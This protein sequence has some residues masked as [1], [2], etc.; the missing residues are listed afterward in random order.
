MAPTLSRLRAVVSLLK[1]PPWPTL[2]T[3]SLFGWLAMAFTSRG[4]DALDLCISA[5]GALLDRGWRAFQVQI[6]MMSVTGVALSLMIML[7]AMMSLILRDPIMHIWNRSLKRRRVRSLGMFF[8]SYCSLWAVCAPML[9]V[10]GMLLRVAASLVDLP[11]LLLALGLV[12]LWQITPWKQ[13]LLNQCHWTPRLSA[14]GWAADRDCLCYG[15]REGGLCVGTCW[16]LMVLPFAVH[17]YHLLFM[18]AAS[19]I[20]VSERLRPGRPA[21]WTIAGPAGLVYQGALKR[22]RRTTN[23][24]PGCF[25]GCD[26]SRHAEKSA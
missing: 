3:F 26:P 6:S 13:R 25:D 4:N 19:T 11:V 22:L 18:A 2:L 20:M 16:A 21:R 15:L 10:L 7:I 8:V 12:G 9:V 5:S 23:T 17:D 1:E 14:F 24:V